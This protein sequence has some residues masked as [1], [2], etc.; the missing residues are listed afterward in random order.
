MSDAKTKFTLVAPAGLMQRLDAYR[1]EF[2]ERTGARLSMN[3]AAC[4]L[5]RGGLDAEQA[6]QQPQ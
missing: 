5:L 6:K 3:Q 4:M 2:T 1:T